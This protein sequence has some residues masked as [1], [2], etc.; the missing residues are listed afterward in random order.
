MSLSVHNREVP[1]YMVF[2]GFCICAQWSVSLCTS[3]RLH[4]HPVMNSCGHAFL[5]RAHPA[6]NFEATIKLIGDTS[7]LSLEVVSDKKINFQNLLQSSRNI[8]KKSLSDD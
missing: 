4:M 5:D 6:R 1:L 7:R 3:G 2:K 8:V